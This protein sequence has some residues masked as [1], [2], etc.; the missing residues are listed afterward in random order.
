MLKLVNVNKTYNKIF[1]RSGL[2]GIF[3]DIFYPDNNLIHALKDINIKIGKG[4]KIGIVGKNG[5]GKS[6]LIKLLCSVIRPTSGEILYNN[7]SLYSDLNNYKQS[8]GVMF[9][10]RTQLSWE[11]AFQESLELLSEIYKIPKIQ[12]KQRI[13]Y[14]A[15][16]LDLKELLKTSIREMSLGQRI[17][18]DI[19]T[20]FLHKPQIIFL[21]EPTIGIDLEFKETIHKFIN[22]ICSN[23][24]AT[25]LVTSHDTADIINLTQRLIILDSGTVITDVPTNEFVTKYQSRKKICLHFSSK[26]DRWLKKEFE[27]KIEILS[28]ENRSVEFLID[29]K[30]TTSDILNMLFNPSDLYDIKISVED[31]SQILLEFYKNI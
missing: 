8:I 1:R 12:A 3:K 10:Q 14:L 25:L 13:D 6:T 4:E 24:N 18:C 16:F 7:K 17:R 9:G 27:T 5:S 30:T 31:M 22:E 21:D 15:E 19:A 26:I 11:L 2:S 28:Q 20:I 23:E 29:K